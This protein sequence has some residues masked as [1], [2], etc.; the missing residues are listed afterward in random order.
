M[1]PTKQRGSLWEVANKLYPTFQD[2]L[3]KVNEMVQD[4]VDAKNGVGGMD[5]DDV[6]EE[7]GDWTNTGEVLTG[8]GAQGEETLFMLQRKGNAFRV[9]PK[10]KGKGGGRA[11][12]RAGKAGG[13]KGENKWDPNGCAR[14]GRSNHW[15]RECVATK[16]VN[17]E[18]PK[19]KPSN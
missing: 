2:L 8:K 12:G 7:E 15:A 6:A 18:P 9:A 19:E 13:A 4:E 3:Q 5:L 1:L 10:G 11:G 17:G 16:D 14:C